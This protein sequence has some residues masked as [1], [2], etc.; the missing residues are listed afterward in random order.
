MNCPKCNKVIV[1][2]DYC[3]HEIS[4][5]Y[6]VFYDNFWDR[7]G[8]ITQIYSMIGMDGEPARLLMCKG[9]VFLDKDRIEKLLLLK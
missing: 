5:E 4:L 9:F 2:T 6:K 1:K 7:E 3:S 8:L